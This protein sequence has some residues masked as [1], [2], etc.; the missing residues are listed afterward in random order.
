MLNCNGLQDVAVGGLINSVGKDA[1]KLTETKPGDETETQEKDLGEYTQFFVRIVVAFKSYYNKQKAKKKPKETDHQ[2]NERLVAESS[3]RIGRLTHVIAWAA[4]AGVGVSVLNYL[5]VEG[6]L[7]AMR[8]QESD[9]RAQ[10]RASIAVEPPM[11]TVQTS[12]QDQSIQ[13]WTIAAVWK[14]EGV[15]ASLDTDAWFDVKAVSIAEANLYGCPDPGIPKGARYTFTKPPGEP[16]VGRPITIPNSVVESVVQ[17][18]QIIFVYGIV[19]Y[20]D[21]FSEDKPYTLDWCYAINPDIPDKK[22]DAVYIR[23]STTQ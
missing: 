3:Q 1:H 2:K 7:K 4:V 13:S 22:L 15:T 12:T 16:F 6:Q 14:N 20:R 8:D 19:K 21:I 17:R 18:S 11:E 23:E 10:I 5:A 9:T